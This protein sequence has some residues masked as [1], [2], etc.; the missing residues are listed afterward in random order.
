MPETD[1]GFR[2]VPENEKASLVEK[3]FSSVASH[4]DVMN[5]VMSLGIHRLWKDAMITEL[6]PASNS[7]LL[8]VAGGTGDIAFRYL[9]RASQGNVT[10]YDINPDMLAQGKKNAIDR[11][12]LSG[13]T[14]CEGNAESLP[15]PDHSFDYYTIAFGI[16]NVTHINLALEE[17]FRVLR[18]GGRFLCLEFSKVSSPLLSKCYDAFS[19]Q[20]I[21]KMGEIVAGDRASYQYLVESIRR[22]PNQKTFLEMIQKAGFA[23][24]SYRNMTGGVVAL[25]SGWKV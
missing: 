18:P 6:S 13:I 22:F 7:Q 19:F 1:F 12:I 4:Y 24:T 8:D 17:A 21:P 3:V 16:R 9:Q 25:H 11:N 2:T 5:D 20:I 15:F 10:V 23:Q 14:W